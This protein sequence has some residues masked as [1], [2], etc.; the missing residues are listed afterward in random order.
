MVASCMPIML[1]NNNCE[2][3]SELMSAVHVYMIQY[4]TI[5]HSHAY[6]MSQFFR[7]FSLS[8]VF[9]VFLLGSPLCVAVNCTAYNLGPKFIPSPFCYSQDYSAY[10]GIVSH[11]GDSGVS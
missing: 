5:Q 4:S 8:Y 1:F 10:G 2:F 3:L 6:G 7:G 9:S 11:M